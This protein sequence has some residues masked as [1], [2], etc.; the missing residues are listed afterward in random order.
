[1]VVAKVEDASLGYLTQSWFDVALLDWLLVWR[2]TPV[3]TVE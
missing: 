2:L 3:A 1:M